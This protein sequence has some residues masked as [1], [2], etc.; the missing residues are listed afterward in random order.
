MHGN[1]A[2]GRQSEL[3][4]WLMIVIDRAADAGHSLGQRHAAIKGGGQ[5]VEAATSGGFG[6][7]NLRNGCLQ[8]VASTDDLTSKSRAVYGVAWCRWPRRVA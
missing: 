5:K 3:R 6:W 7:S 8:Q 1:K 4:L 2:E